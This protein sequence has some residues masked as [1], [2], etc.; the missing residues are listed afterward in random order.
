MR[1][2]A[3]ISILALFPAYTAATLIAG[4]LNWAAYAGA[5]A[6]SCHNVDWFIETAAELQSFGKEKACECLRAR[7]AD[8]N[9]NEREK[10]FVLCRMLFVAKPGGEFR[11][12][13][14]GGP[15]FIGSVKIEDWP[16]EPI[17]IV[18]GIPFLVTYGYMLAGYPEPAPSY[19][20]YCVRECDW[21]SERFT[22][23][24][25]TEKRHALF[26]LFS[27]RLLSQSDKEFLA[28]QIK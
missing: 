27:K 25:S 18:D 3:V 23:R 12:P 13:L 11:R 14:L 16:L 15:Y 1:K 19:V 2:L 17:E 7:A 26:K 24:N 28:S 6:E 4:S 9:E 5:S 8:K 10:T 22:P 21:S 20:E